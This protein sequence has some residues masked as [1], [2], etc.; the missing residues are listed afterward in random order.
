MNWP[1]DKVTRTLLYIAAIGMA[2]SGSLLIIFAVVDL[3]PAWEIAWHAIYRPTVD[4]TEWD[5]VLYQ[6]YYAAWVQ[7]G[8]GVL[9]LVAG[10]LALGGAIYQG[11]QAVM[12][13]I[14]TIAAE[15]DRRELARAEA[16]GAFA[17]IVLEELRILR[18]DYLAAA[19][20]CRQQRHFNRASGLKGT[21][22]TLG[23]YTYQAPRTFEAPWT[24]W[25]SLGIMG[26]SILVH[27]RSGHGF[28]LEMEKNLRNQSKA[29]D[30]FRTPQSEAQE[31]QATVLWIKQTHRL[32][33]MMRSMRVDL[34][35]IRNEAVAA[36]TRALRKIRHRQAAERLDPL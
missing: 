36:E 31:Y 17:V 29:H 27:A 28:L 9:A 13:A 10:A 7:L 25:A 22:L 24:D 4:P 5:K 26:A 2:V 19:R 6:G 34:E 12:A 20:K 30:A 18:I 11:R 21:H 1:R 8:A 33:R 16:A 14:T 35:R 23:D 32:V 15:D 3:T